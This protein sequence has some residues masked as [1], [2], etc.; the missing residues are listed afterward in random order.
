[1]KKRGYTVF[2]LGRNEVLRFPPQL[3]SRYIVGTYRTASAFSFTD[4]KPPFVIAVCTTYAV[5][6]TDSYICL[7]LN[8]YMPLLIILA[9]V[10]YPPYLCARI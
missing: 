8:R 4:V 1:M 3:E 6:G 5:V 2:K 10:R 7:A 9:C